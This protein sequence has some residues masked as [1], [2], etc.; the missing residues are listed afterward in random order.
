MVFELPGFT[1]LEANINQSIAIDFG[2]WSQTS[3]A[4]ASSTN[5]VEAGKTYKVIT[6]NVVGVSDGDP[7]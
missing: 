2:S 7:S 5:S 6:R 4:A 3:T 1:D